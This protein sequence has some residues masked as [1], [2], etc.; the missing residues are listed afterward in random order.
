MITTKTMHD[1]YRI[2]TH[3]AYASEGFEKYTETERE[4][5][6]HRQLTKC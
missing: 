6:R 2:T 4:T 1:S 5:C 3:T